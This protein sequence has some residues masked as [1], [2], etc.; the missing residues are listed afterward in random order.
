M[1]FS[2]IQDEVLSDRFDA[3]KRPSVKNWIN[4]RYGRL[5]GMMPWT[6]KYQI[7][8]LTI[9]QGSSTVARG[10]SIGRIEAIYDYT[11]ST[12]YSATGP[13]R[14]ED[15]YAMASLNSGTPFNWTVV[16]DNIIFDRPA[17]GTRTLTVVNEQ[18]WTQLVND[19]DTP[20]IPTEFHLLLAFG[21][22]SHGLKLEN[23]PSWESHEADWQ[24]G[25]E[26]MKANY[27]TPVVTFEDVYPAWP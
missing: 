17:S 22:A 4:Y 5:W 3:S 18:K 10:S 19:S 16:G 15:F 26:D 1:T 8:P 6:F 21:A 24:Q 23:D 11:N 27:L 25:I 14:P 13:L 2:Q 7:S 20:L 9:P 12:S